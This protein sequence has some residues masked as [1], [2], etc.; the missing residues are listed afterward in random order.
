M[1][2]HYLPPSFLKGH[3]PSFL[4]H[5]AESA[6]PPSTIV[7][8]LFSFSSL[9]SDSHRAIVTHL[10]LGFPPSFAANND[11]AHSIQAQ[12]SVCPPPLLPFPPFLPTNCPSPETLPG[13]PP[14]PRSPP[15]THRNTPSECVLL[16]QVHIKETNPLPPSP[17]SDTP[18]PRP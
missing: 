1:H 2:M 16:T 11:D 15:L 3:L 13:P 7:L 18:P 12:S 17:A 14:P 8:S 5:C 9:R 6:F 10:S 4:S